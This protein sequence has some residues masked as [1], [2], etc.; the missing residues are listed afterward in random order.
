MVLNDHK[1]KKETF[2]V[3]V[4]DI[5]GT[6][7]RYLSSIALFVD[8][9]WTI[10]YGYVQDENNE[11][12]VFPIIIR[13][14]ISGVRNKG[15]KQGY[16]AG[17]IDL[18]KEQHILKEQIDSLK[19]GDPVNIIKIDTKRI[20]IAPENEILQRGVNALAMLSEKEPEIAMMALRP[21][22]KELSYQRNLSEFIKKRESMRQKADRTLTK[23][24]AIVINHLLPTIFPKSFEDAIEIRQLLSDYLVPFRESMAQ[25]TSRVQYDDNYRYFEEQI[26]QIVRG[27]LEPSL[28]EIESVLKKPTKRILK[29]LISDSKYPPII[30]GS[31]V[32]T[33]LAIVG[34]NAVT[35]AAAA[36]SITAAVG[37][38]IFKEIAKRKEIM[39]PRKNGLAYIL[40]IK[41]II[42]K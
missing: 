4:S 29:H 32:L 42:N 3:C 31:A 20:L 26:Y 14:Q 34:G 11:P 24:G 39:D 5:L 36:A 41:Q 6:Y 27:E 19:P 21:E 12:G 25:L 17:Y 23:T 35:A 10:D 28:R 18:K 8:E 38:S 37:G 15:E 9:L 13:E 2:K 1:Q 16:F 40:K 30:I 33:T 7:S 22:S